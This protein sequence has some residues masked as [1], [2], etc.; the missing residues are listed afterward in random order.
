MMD[1]KIDLG[2]WIYEKF[3]LT[4]NISVKNKIP[5]YVLYD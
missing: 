4:T 5:F 1:V 3:G 2:S